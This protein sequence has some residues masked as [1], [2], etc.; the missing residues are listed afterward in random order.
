MTTT[1]LNR[2]TCSPYCEM[3]QTKQWPHPFPRLAGAGSQHRPDP[4]QS[5]FVTQHCPPGGMRASTHS[6]S[7]A[8]ASGEGASALLSSPTPSSTGMESSP[9][10]N[11]G[12][13]TLPAR[14]L[15]VSIDGPPSGAPLATTPPHDVAAANAIITAKVGRMR[16]GGCSQQGGCASG[17]THGRDA[18]QGRPGVLQAMR[19]RYPQERWWMKWFDGC[20]RCSSR[21][22]PDAVA[23]PP[24]LRPTPAST[25][26]SRPKRPPTAPCDAG[27]Y[28]RPLRPTWG[29]SFNAR[30]VSSA[31]RPVASPA[32]FAVRRTNATSARAF[33]ASR[34]LAAAVRR[35]AEEL[36]PARSASARAEPT[37]PR[38]SA[39]GPTTCS[40][41]SKEGQ[42]RPHVSGDNGCAGQSC[43]QA[44]TAHR[45]RRTLA[46]AASIRRS[47]VSRG[48]KRKRRSDRCWDS[49]SS[50]PRHLP[51]CRRSCRERKAC[52]R[53]QIPCRCTRRAARPQARRAGHR[54]RRSRS[55]GQR[56][57]TRYQDPHR[58]PSGS[59][60]RHTRVSSTQGG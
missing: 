28:P 29:S 25:G 11:A 21:E 20:W 50:C 27:R 9:A 45:A 14:G 33:L 7:H 38:R 55:R 2:A 5:M 49:S 10:S 44:A 58:S 53:H 4:P 31:A 36:R 60:G 19:W 15:L 22:Q 40:A 48:N 42:A 17:R 47:A 43:R 56:R 34:L 26:R 57:S 52:R 18:A 32:S 37:C 8:A 3:G 16:L 39:T 35:I 54:R 30:A 24:S 6:G 41:A 59:S 1:R 13:A 46:T 12:G 51:S 23:E